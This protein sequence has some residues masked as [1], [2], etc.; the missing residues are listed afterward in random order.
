MAL[1]ETGRNVE[2]KLHKEYCAHFPEALY[3]LRNLRFQ[4]F[5]SSIPSVLYN[6][7]TPQFLDQLYFLSVFNQGKSDTRTLP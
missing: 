6:F 5:K 3:F 7:L 1:L 2:A 4:F